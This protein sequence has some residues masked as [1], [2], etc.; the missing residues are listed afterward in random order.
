M[1]PEQRAVVV[2][3]GRTWIGT[4]FCLNAAVKGNSPGMG[5]VDCCRLALACYNA[6]GFALGSPDSFPRMRA[7]WNV[8]TRE[9]AVLELLMAKLLPVDVPEPGSNLAIRMG[10]VY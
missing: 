8:H 3:E 2:A 1:T 4:K 7:G 5:G 10:H 9:E 6:A